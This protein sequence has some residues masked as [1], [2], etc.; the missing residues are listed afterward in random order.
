MPVPELEPL[1]QSTDVAT[2]LGVSAPTVLPQ[3]MQTR[4]APTLRKVSRRFRFEAQRFFTPGTY[5]HTLRI[6]AGAVRLMEVPNMIQRVRV[7]GLPMADWNSIGLTGVQQAVDEDSGEFVELPGGEANTASDT[8]ANGPLFHVEA[9]WLTWD[10]W[11]FWRLNG[12]MA[13]I[14]Y[15]WDT[16][17]PQSVT[18]TVAAITGR[19]LT[20]DPLGALAQ[21][22][23]LMTRHYR[24]EVA[25]W[26]SSGATDLMPEEIEQAQSYR[27]PAPPMIVA[28]MSMVEMSPSAAFLADSSW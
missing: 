20:V 28:Q 16:P 27:Y 4:M 22:K 14:T 25:D 13:E 17:V 5:T 6:H 26:V 10:D 7:Q 11:D 18:D 9:N 8:V 3:T 23:L 15:S 12:R 21:S 1:A 2:A 19:M 24:Q